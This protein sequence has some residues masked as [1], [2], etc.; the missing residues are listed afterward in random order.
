VSR[1]TLKSA[2]SLTDSTKYNKQ[3]NIIDNWQLSQY[4]QYVFQ[5]TSRWFKLL[6]FSRNY[7]FQKS[8]CC[9][10]HLGTSFMVCYAIV[11]IL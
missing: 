6:H 2:Q 4:K 11:S 5:R 3:H 10:Y 8:I 7:S 1:G 9:D